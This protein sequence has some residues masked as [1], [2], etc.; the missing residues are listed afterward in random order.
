MVPGDLRGKFGPGMSNVSPATPLNKQKT[1]FFGGPQN[2]PQ[3]AG[4]VTYCY[5]K[6]PRVV[7]SGPGV[8]G[9]TCHALFHG[10]DI[11]GTWPAIFAT[12]SIFVRKVAETGPMT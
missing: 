9:V 12:G 3:T 10:C 11:G 5:S 7:F 6:M 8:Q 1:N 4:M 2:G